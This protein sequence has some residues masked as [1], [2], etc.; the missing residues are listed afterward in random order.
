[1][2][3]FDEVRLAIEPYV[4]MVE[5]YRA[6]AHEHARRLLGDEMFDRMMRDKIR[7]LG[8]APEYVYPWNVEAYMIIA[9][10]ESA[11]VT[12]SDAGNGR[13]KGPTKNA[14][15]FERHGVNTKMLS[16]R[17]RCDYSGGVSLFARMGKMLTIE[18]RPG[19]RVV[20][21]CKGVCIGYIERHPMK[22]HHMS[23]D[24]VDELQITREEI[25]SP[26][27]QAAFA[28]YLAAKKA[29]PRKVRA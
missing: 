24:A 9:E 14:T 12:P 23:L 22:E 16:P 1:M 18:R 17:G 8:P 13:G 27:Q 3:L 21:F 15:P 28:K 29:R 11:P 19:E 25:L 5:Q 2:G 20:L 10:Q 7:C 4:V 26:E 6:V